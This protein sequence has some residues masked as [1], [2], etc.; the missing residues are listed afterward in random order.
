MTWLPV[1]V[2]SS[3][4]HLFNSWAFARPLMDRF[5]LQFSGGSGFALG[6]LYITITKICLEAIVKE[7][8]PLWLFTRICLNLV[9]APLRD[10]SSKKLWSYLLVSCYRWHNSISYCFLDSLNF[11]F[12]LQNTLYN[13]RRNTNW[14]LNFQITL[15]K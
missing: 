11:N 3:G 4:S 15:I 9:I 14:L 10:S 13:S 5:V 8:G 7:A 2:K 1:F 12:L 6:T